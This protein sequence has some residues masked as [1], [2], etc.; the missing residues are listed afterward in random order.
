MTLALVLLALLS[1][2]ATTTDPTTESGATAMAHY[3][4]VVLLAPLGNA[5]AATGPSCRSARHGV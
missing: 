2:A 1:L 5:S 3:L 4:D